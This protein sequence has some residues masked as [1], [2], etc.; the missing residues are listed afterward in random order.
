[1]TVDL[2]KNCPLLK[3]IKGSLNAVR[4]ERCSATNEFIRV[5]DCDVTVSTA[6]DNE[7]LAYMLDLDNIDVDDDDYDE[8]DEYNNDDYDNDAYLS[9]DD[10][11][12][13]GADI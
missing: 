11:E 2:A 6:L 5:F 10:D 4:Y 1:V 7:G 12:E 8:Y 13:Y 3:Q 9:Y